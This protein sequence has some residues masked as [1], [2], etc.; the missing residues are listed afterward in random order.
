MNDKKT[1]LVSIVINFAILIMTLI[2]WFCMMFMSNGNLSS[3]GIG[4]LKYFTVLSNLL[5]GIASGIFAV[6][7][8]IDLKNDKSVPIWAMLLKYSATVS[9]TLT[10]L[11]VVF[12]L[13]P[14]EVINGGSY[15]SMFLGAN[16]F[17]HFI[18]PVIAILDF[19]LLEFKPSLQFKYSVTGLIPMFLYAIFYLFNVSLKLVASEFDGIKTY[20]WYGF[21][22]DGNIIRIIIVILIM[23]LATYLISLVIYFLN[24]L[25]RHHFIGYDNDE[26]EVV[27]VEEDNSTNESNVLEEE[28]IEDKIVGHVGDGTVVDNM[29]KKIVKN[30][31]DGYDEVV[32]TYTTDTGT[33]HT[34]TKK[35]IKEYKE[36][37]KKATSTRNTAKINRYKNGARTYHISRHIF[38]NGWQ[39]RLANGEKAIKLFNTQ[40]EAIDY[41]KKL[42]TTQGGSIRIHSKKGK[43]RK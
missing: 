8:L 14:V 36:E 40:K 18:I 39:V 17:F 29:D 7:K 19:V 1:R 5:V 6:F 42:V 10:L 35:V 15:F 41:A 4:S 24:T 37:Q 43:L 27:S 28:I 21:F 26:G 25:S 23:L 13:A 20:D 3:S 31:Y 32:E 11:V 33:I 16:L 9:V 38:S 22:G 2:S 30:S 34:I 12:Y